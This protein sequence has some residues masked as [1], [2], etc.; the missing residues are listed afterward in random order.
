MRHLFDGVSL[1]DHLGNLAPL[2]EIYP[3]QHAPIIRSTAEGFEMVMGRWGMPTPAP[4]LVGKKTD[5]GVTNIR[6][7]ASPHWRQWSA[8]SHR[9]LVP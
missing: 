4:F 5:R 3:D 7:A 8:T 2:A 9:C 6:N 1:T